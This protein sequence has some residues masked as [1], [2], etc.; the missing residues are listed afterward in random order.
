[1][2]DGGG[3]RAITR[4]ACRAPGKRGGRLTW[5][6]TIRGI[7]VLAWCMVAGQARPARSDRTS[8]TRVRDAPARRLLTSL[9]HGHVPPARVAPRALAFGTYLLGNFRCRRLIIVITDDLGSAGDVSRPR[10]RIG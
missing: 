6:P 9:L 3:G 8:C 10:R 4:V 1:L 2:D 7:V 5:F